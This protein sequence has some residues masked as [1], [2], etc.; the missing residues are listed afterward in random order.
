MR[1]ALAPTT[2]CLALVMGG[3]GDSFAQEQA[4]PS[5]IEHELQAWTLFA[6]WGRQDRVRFYAEAQPRVRIDDGQLDRLLLRPAVGYALTPATSLWL[7]YAWTP[8]FTPQFRNEHR[9]FQQLLFEHKFGLVSLVNRARL[10][11]RFIEDAG[12]M[13][14]RARHMARGLLRLGHGSRVSLVVFDEIFVNANGVARGPGAGF[15][16]NRLFAGLNVRL[17]DWQIET[18]YMNN[19]VVRPNSDRMNHNLMTMVVF[20]LP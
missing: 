17:G 7:G 14:W 8:S 15:D 2:C 10:E 19:Y 16:Q 4:A 3:M 13:S 5:G 20:V 11:Q 6:A 1:A 18:G 9:P 12:G